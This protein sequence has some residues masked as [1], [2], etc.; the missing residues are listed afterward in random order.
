MRNLFIATAMLFS[1]VGAA[2]AEPFKEVTIGIPVS[3][4]LGAEE[5]YAKFLGPNIEVI[6]PFPGVVEIKATPNVWLQL[7]ETEEQQ[8][9]ATVIRFLVSDMAEAQDARSNRDIDTG[10]A[11]EIPGVVT[12]SEFCER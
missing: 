8:P 1:I 2:S 10:T 12:Y 9:T 11:I 5:W 6:K 3:E 4:I 7:F